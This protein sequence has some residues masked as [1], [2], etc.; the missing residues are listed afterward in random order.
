[1]QYVYF[2]WVQ[3]SNCSVE[4]PD[5]DTCMCANAMDT[6]QQTWHDKCNVRVCSLP[7]GHYATLQRILNSDLYLAKMEAESWLNLSAAHD[8]ISQGPTEPPSNSMTVMQNFT[9]D[10]EK[11]NNMHANP[12]I[13]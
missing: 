12:M 7:F 9:T 3:A 1:M 5:Q 4:V 13:S 10:C 11:L 2:V 6:F 8:F